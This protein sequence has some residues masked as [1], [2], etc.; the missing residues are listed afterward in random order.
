MSRKR[1]REQVRLLQPIFQI[2]PQLSF[3][4]VPNDQIDDDDIKIRRGAKGVHQRVRGQTRHATG[5]RRNHTGDSNQDGKQHRN[6]D[7]IQG[8]PVLY[9][10]IFH[11]FILVIVE[12]F[13]RVR[14][15]EHE[16]DG[17]ENGKEPNLVRFPISHR[18][19]ARDV[20]P[21]QIGRTRRLHRLPLAKLVVNLYGT[22]DQSIFL[23]FENNHGPGGRFDGVDFLFANGVELL[24]ELCLFLDV[25]RVTFRRLLQFES[26]NTG[27]SR[28]T[29][30]RLR[31]D[32]FLFR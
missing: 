10:D 31:V 4:H 23:I 30:E 26:Q 16:E 32:L 6:H 21:Y 19:R 29:F 17:D 7:G 13:C 12:Q 11:D 15:W 24:E 18:F 22:H 8:F 27:T 2:E 9:A 25:L 3:G 28:R 1:V 5:N 14:D 20:V